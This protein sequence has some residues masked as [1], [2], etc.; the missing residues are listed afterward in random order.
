MAGDIRGW[1]SRLPNVASCTL[2]PRLDDVLVVVVSKDE[3]VDG[4]LDDAI[5]KLDLEMFSRNKFRMTW[6]ML[7]ASE[8]NGIASFVK[9]TDARCIYR[10][11]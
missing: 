1:C 11:V 4:Q 9:S 3:D 10:A 8:A 6:L 2:C 5:S 7:R